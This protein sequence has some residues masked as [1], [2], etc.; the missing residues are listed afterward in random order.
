MLIV[1]KR[2]LNSIE[3]NKINDTFSELFKNTQ[4]EFSMPLEVEEDIMSTIYDDS[5]LSQRIESLRRKSLEIIKIAAGLLLLFLGLTIIYA[6]GME[7]Y[8]FTVTLLGIGS[9]YFLLTFY[10]TIGNTE[11][12]LSLQ[13]KK[14]RD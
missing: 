3:M 14:K 1:F 7:T 11:V 5:L 4:R 9:F 13:T 8:F 2:I 6:D 10:L 12:N